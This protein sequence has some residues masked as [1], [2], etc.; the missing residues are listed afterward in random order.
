MLTD[1]YGRFILLISKCHLTA[2]FTVIICMRNS[3][4][5]FW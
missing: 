3:S 1:T 2:W 5:E 4:R